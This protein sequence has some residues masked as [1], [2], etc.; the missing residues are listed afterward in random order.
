MDC[1]DGKEKLGGDNIEWLVF[2]ACHLIHPADS[3]G[4][5]GTLTICVSILASST[6][7]YDLRL[8][9]PASILDMILYGMNLW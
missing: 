6:A 4:G 5:L 8:D 9:D 2:L 1:H 3:I 7:C